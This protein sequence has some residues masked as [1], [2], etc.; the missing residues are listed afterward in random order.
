MGCSS[1]RGKKRWGDGLQGR[2]S[3]PRG[4]APSP[5]AQGRLASRPRGKGPHVDSRPSYLGPF[6]PTRFSGAPPG[7]QP[8]CPGRGWAGKAAAEVARN[9]LPRAPPGRACCHSSRGHREWAQARWAGAMPPRSGAQG[10]GR[11]LQT[12]LLNSTSILFPE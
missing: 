10:T 5:P 9:W 1:I 4:G 6:L 11:P 2:D 12:H 3:R 8:T 7:Q